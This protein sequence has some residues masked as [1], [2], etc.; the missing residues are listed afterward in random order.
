MLKLGYRKWL[1]HHICRIF[2]STNFAHNNITT[3][4]NITNKMIPN[5][6]VFCSLM[7]HLIF[8]K[9][10]GTLTIKKYCA[11]LKVFI[12]FTKESLQPNSFFTSLSNRHVLSFSGRQSDCSLQSGFPTDCTTSDCKDITCE[13][14]SS[15]KF[16]SKININIPNV[17]I[18]SSSK[19]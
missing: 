13:R 3:S 14:S 10:D 6:N 15:I 4:N 16:S 9:E 19:F 18:S 8:C 5:I 7:K 2:M 11:D 17:S 1:S 12:E